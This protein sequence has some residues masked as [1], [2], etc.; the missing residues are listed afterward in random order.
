MLLE[1]IIITTIINLLALCGISYLIYDKYNTILCDIT[2]S[3]EAISELESFTYHSESEINDW[4][5]DKTRDIQYDIDQH[6]SDIEDLS[7]NKITED[8]IEESHD[9]LKKSINEDFENIGVLIDSNRVRI[10]NITKYL[11]KTSDF[12]KTLDSKGEPIKKDTKNLE[13]YCESFDFMDQWSDKRLSEHYKCL[14]M[15]LDDGVYHQ[16]YLGMGCETT[17]KYYLQLTEGDLK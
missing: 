14:S 10:K 7:Y 13:S 9:K 4:I 17:Y 6:S 2:R 16:D 5:D 8:D 15:M 11:S 12:K 1:I 3:E